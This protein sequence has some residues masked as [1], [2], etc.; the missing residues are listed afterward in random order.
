MVHHQAQLWVRIEHRTQKRQI[1]GNER[2]DREVQVLADCKD[3]L[4][5]AS[6]KVSQALA[7]QRVSEDRADTDHTLRGLRGAQLRRNIAMPGSNHG[8]GGKPVWEFRD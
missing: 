7:R 2:E 4:P 8:D 6:L 3:L 1:A 5:K